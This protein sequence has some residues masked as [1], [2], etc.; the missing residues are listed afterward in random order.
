M[1]YKLSNRNIV[2]NIDSI[3]YI[4]LEDNIIYF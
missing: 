4:D 3:T 2:I 1:F